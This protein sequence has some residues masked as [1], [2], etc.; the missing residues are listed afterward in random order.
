[1]IGLDQ[2]GRGASLFG[3]APR[4][5]H[6]SGGPTRSLTQRGVEPPTE[7]FSE[8]FLHRYFNTLGPAGLQNCSCITRHCKTE[9]ALGSPVGRGTF[10]FPKS[11]VPLEDATPW[12]EAIRGRPCPV[13]PSRAPSGR[14]ARCP[15]QP[16]WASRHQGNHQALSGIPTRLSHA[17]QDVVLALERHEA[18]IR[19]DRGHL[20]PCLERHHGV[21]TT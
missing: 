5:R 2:V 21:A 4:A 17:A 13:S 19:N 11:S 14:T 18:G 20:P 12:P 15:P 10:R 6:L 8:A 1:M 16:R 9:H 3:L 7:R